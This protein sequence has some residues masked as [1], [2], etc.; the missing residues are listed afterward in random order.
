MDTRRIPNSCLVQSQSKAD[1]HG[2]VKQTTW[3]AH[4]NTAWNNVTKQ[5][6]A[7]KQLLANTGL[8]LQRR[9]AQVNKQPHNHHRGRHSGGNSRHFLQAKHDCQDHWQGLQ[10]ETQ[11]FTVAWKPLLTSTLRIKGLSG[12]KPITFLVACYLVTYCYPALSPEAC[13]AK[14]TNITRHEGKESQENF[15]S[16]SLSLSINS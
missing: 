15:R 3:K 14:C 6:T 4:W 8:Q 1:T 13:L 10:N 16:V 12:T 2:E 7:G 5:Q 11:R 9:G